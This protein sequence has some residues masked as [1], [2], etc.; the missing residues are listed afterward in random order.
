MGIP[1]SHGHRRFRLNSLR[2]AVKPKMKPPPNQGLS[3]FVA[4]SEDD[5]RE[6]K[7]ASDALRTLYTCD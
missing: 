2:V 1:F 3:N 6:A 5:V 7:E 4:G